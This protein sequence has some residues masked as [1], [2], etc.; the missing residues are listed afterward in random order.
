M[1]LLTLARKAIQSKLEAKQ[2]KIDEKTKTQ[3]NKKQACFVTL[4]LNNQLRGCIGSLL[5][6]QSLYQDVVENSANAAFH[7]PRFLPLTKSELKQVKIEISILSI[8][9]KL[10]YK[11][12]QD[13]LKKIKSKG[14]IIKHGWNSATYL[15]QVWEQISEPEEFISNLCI[16][17]GLPPDTW[18][19]EKLEIQT[20][21]VE[22]IKEG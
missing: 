19:S 20:Y 3:F 13:L 10:K 16:K 18:K 7:D 8:P 4:T 15:P 6:H 9:K 2:I 1:N 22:K 17:A 14:V 12:S 5:P 21:E 11:N